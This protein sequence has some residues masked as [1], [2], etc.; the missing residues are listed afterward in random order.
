MSERP[1]QPVCLEH[2]AW[3]AIQEMQEAGRRMLLL[4]IGATEQHG[5]HLPINTDTIIADAC[6]RAASEAT[7]VPVLPPLVYTVSMGHT[8]HWP[9]TFSLTHETFLRTIREL[10]DWAVAT[11]WTKLLLINAHFGN[12]ATLRA[13]VERIRLD[14]LGRL[15]IGLRHTFS[16]T[17][18][19]WQYF[20]SDAD[21][22]HANQAETD[23]LLHLAPEHVW[24]ERVA[25][26]PDRTADTI[27]SYPVVQT[28]RN[29]V[30]GAPSRGTAERG[31]SLFAEMTHALTKIA[32]Q[33]QLE[34]PPLPAGPDDA[35]PHGA[36]L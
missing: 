22:L 20:I 36:P 31:R 30:T 5:P 7:G 34:Q 15:Q 16:L 4:P 19:I 11:G 33:A 9:G 14:H 29:G 13:A 6:A 23:L 28:S 8:A 26:D 18:T 3:P 25:D 10:A 12:D 27:F 32:R 1:T 24:M 2:L 35:W 17:P 21:D